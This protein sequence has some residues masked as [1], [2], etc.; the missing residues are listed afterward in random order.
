MNFQASAFLKCQPENF[1]I[2]TVHDKLLLVIIGAL[3]RV[4]L[5]LRIG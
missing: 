3:I 1:T 2:Q 5:L 4:R